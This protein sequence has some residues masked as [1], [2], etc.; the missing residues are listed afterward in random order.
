M[1]NYTNWNGVVGRYPVAAAR[2]PTPEMQNSFI[3]GAEGEIDGY[4]AKRYTLPLTPAPAF[5]TTLT[6][7]LAYW[8]M[9][10]AQKGSKEL[11]QS[12]DARLKL[13][14]DGGV[15][16]TSSGSTFATG[17]VAWAENTQ[18]TVFGPDDPLNWRP[19]A[20]YLEDVETGRDD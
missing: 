3:V 14:S 10:F 2:A 19:S 8:M 7:D 1:G 11:R 6:I 20:T 12:I 5:L 13:I 17:N 15:I 16:L 9:T 18:Q 4:V